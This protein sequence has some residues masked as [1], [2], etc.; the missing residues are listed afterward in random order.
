LKWSTT[1]P[2]ICALLEFHFFFSHFSFCPWRISHWN[3]KENWVLKNVKQRVSRK[4]FIFRNG[5]DRK[6]QEMVFLETYQSMLNW[7][8][9][10]NYP[11]KN[12]GKWGKPEEFTENFCE[13]KKFLLEPQYKNS[14]ISGLKLKFGGFSPFEQN[15]YSLQRNFWIHESCLSRPKYLWIFKLKFFE[16]KQR[17]KD[18]EFDWNN[19]FFQTWKKE[20]NDSNKK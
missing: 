6:S 4:F 19:S 18:F 7:E 17:K 15:F 5:R 1:H 13:E 16:E 12:F 14:F 11:T 20:R 9:Q 8:N 2:K 3:S 10:S